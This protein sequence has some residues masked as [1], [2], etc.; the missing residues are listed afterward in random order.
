M[1]F[2][3]LGIIEM[4]MFEEG[5]FWSSNYCVIHSGPKSRHRNNRGK[6]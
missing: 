3:I 4:K 5:N 6:K 2:D 1:G